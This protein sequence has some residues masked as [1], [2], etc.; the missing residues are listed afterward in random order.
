MINTTKYDSIIEKAMERSFGK[1]NEISRTCNIDE[2]PDEV[3][4][5][6][7]LSLIGEKTKDEARELIFKTLSELLNAASI[8]ISLTQCVFI[9]IVEGEQVD[10]GK[11]TIYK[12]Y[13]RLDDSFY[14]LHFFL[15]GLSVIEKIWAAGV[16]V[17]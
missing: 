17:D 1:E 8:D 15:D 16:S 12:Q 7:A 13:S 6:V 9:A 14:S 10:V 3:R 11:K 5:I 4:E 2:M